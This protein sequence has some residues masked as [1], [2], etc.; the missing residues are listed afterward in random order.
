MAPRS[1]KSA[2]IFPTSLSS[3]ALLAID[4]TATVVA[5]L[6]AE[7]SVPIWKANGGG[8]KAAS[9]NPTAAVMQLMEAIAAS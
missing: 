3:T 2:K 1:P 7:I 5:G 4:R 8:K 9:E 6:N